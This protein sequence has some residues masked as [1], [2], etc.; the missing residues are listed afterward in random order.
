MVAPLVI[1]GGAALAGVLAGALTKVL[2][3]KPVYA[4]V[5]I[6]GNRVMGRVFGDTNAA[7]AWQ[8]EI[9][10]RGTG[11]L[12][13]EKKDGEYKGLERMRAIAPWS[14]KIVWQKPVKTKL[15]GLGVGARDFDTVEEQEAMT[16]VTTRRPTPEWARRAKEGPYPDTDP[17]RQASMPEVPLFHGTTSSHEWKSDVKTWPVPAKYFPGREGP[18]VQPDE[19]VVE[20]RLQY[21][22]GGDAAEAR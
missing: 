10:K 18:P 9:A 21:P 4:V 20:H 14:G 22:E 17:G 11:S 7:M 13:V 5:Y 6:H 16:L 2:G 8:D 3:Q 15:K 12:L 1:A 19:F